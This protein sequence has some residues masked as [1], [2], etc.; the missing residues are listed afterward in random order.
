[1]TKRTFTVINMRLPDDRTARAR[2]RD[3]AMRLFA[4]RGSAAVTVRDIAAAARV[5]PALV[6]RHYGSKVGL[7]DEVDQHVVASLEAALGHIAS[8]GGPLVGDPSAA[9]TTMQ[10]V[11]TALG[12]DTPL[13][14]YLTRMLVEGTRS[15]RNLFAQ[16]HALSRR[17][18]ASLA[19]TTPVSEGADPA[20]RATV[21][22]VNDLAC[23]M[24]RD[25]IHEVL[26]T[27]PLG[28]E[29]IHAYGGELLAIYSGGLAATNEGI[30]P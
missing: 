27:D 19:A 4:D 5:S 3:E 20:V 1:M 28:P 25:R 11:L 18:L 21:L 23:L 30:Q 13:P 26:G 9:E 12:P 10:S 7:I 8:G 6:I 2:I 29:G 17:T 24:L 15:G 14:R 16:L 22:L